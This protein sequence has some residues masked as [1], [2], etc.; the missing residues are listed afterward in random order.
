MG[1]RNFSGFFDRFGNIGKV[2]N[3]VIEVVWWLLYFK[4]INF[5][6]LIFKKWIGFFGL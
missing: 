4:R 3:V 2:F 6:I 1:N 5:W